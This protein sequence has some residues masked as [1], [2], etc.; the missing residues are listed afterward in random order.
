M[1]SLQQGTGGAEASS[2]E[3]SLGTLDHYSPSHPY[4]VGAWEDAISRVTGWAGDSD[5]SGYRTKWVCFDPPPCR[6][7]GPSPTSG[8][9]PS[10][11]ERCAPQP[12]IVG[13]GLPVVPAKLVAKIHRGEY[14]D[15]A[16]LLKT[17][18]KQRDTILLRKGSRVTR[19]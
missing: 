6:R 8:K 11:A 17:T 14:V 13:E 10:Q 5:N 7:S 9:M 19:F 18:L 2:Q 4:R 16:E 1:S 15:M 3:K 12:F